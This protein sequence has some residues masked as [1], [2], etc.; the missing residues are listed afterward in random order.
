MIANAAVACPEG[1]QPAGNPTSGNPSGCVPYPG[2]QQSQQFQ[3]PQGRWVTQW[4]AIATDENIGTFGAVKNFASKRSAT[5]AALAACKTNG[6]SRCE[7]RLSYYNQCAVLSWGDAFYSVRSEA[8]LELAGKVAS[9]KCDGLT[10]NCK[11]V[12]ADCS[13]PVWIQ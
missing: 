3:Q 1:Q 11:M 2:G 8:T 13:L 12:Y 5:K 7:I 6:G 9:E 10:K 4:G